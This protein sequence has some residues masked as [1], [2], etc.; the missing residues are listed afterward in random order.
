MDIELKTALHT[1]GLRVTPGRV[2]VLTALAEHPHSTAESLR[3]ISATGLSI[4]SVHNVLA[5]LAAARIIRR[6]EQAAFSPANT[7]PGISISPDKM[8][9]ARV[10]SYSEAQ[11]YRVGTNYNE[12]P[13]NAPISPVNS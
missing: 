1:A 9:L 8:L 5:D 2:E 10:M 6:I 11:R 13:V 12:I 3:V 4:Q 7:V